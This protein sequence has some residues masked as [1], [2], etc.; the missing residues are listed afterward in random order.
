MGLFLAN[1]T[2][3]KQST[4]STT[5]D[6][7]PLLVLS[8]DLYERKRTGREDDQPQGTLRTLFKRAGTVVRQSELR[9]W[10]HAADVHKISPVSGPTAGGTVVTL[11]GNYL[12]GVT[13]VTVGG[14]AATAVT[15]LSDRAVRFT[16]PARS[17]GAQ[18]IVITDDKATDTAGGTFTYT[19]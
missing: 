19:A 1:G 14:A 12:D 8:T 4:I 11:E 18:A 5:S 10:F 3:V 13:G 9:A 16:T 17:A 6:P 15:V 2:R 7:D